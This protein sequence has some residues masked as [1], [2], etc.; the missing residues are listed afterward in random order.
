MQNTV[1]N[2]FEDLE[3]LV[4]IFYRY[5]TAVLRQVRQQ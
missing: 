1:N 2:L 4:V 5:I 3:I